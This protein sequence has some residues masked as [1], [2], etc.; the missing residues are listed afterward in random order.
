MS[1][2]KILR[3][4]AIKN[5]QKQGY[6]VKQIAEEYG[7]TTGRVYQILNGDYAKKKREDVALRK[8][9]EWY[10]SPTE[11]QAI[12][13]IEREEERFHKL[14]NTIFNVCELSGF[15]IEERLVIR[16]KRT[17]RVWR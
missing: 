14:L 6:S 4:N 7:L 3:D 13:N 15:R 9:G 5:L 12:K 2:D 16:D 10:N 8:N 1:L 11:Y 17:G